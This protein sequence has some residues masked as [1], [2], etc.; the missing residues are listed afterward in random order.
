LSVSQ[1][2]QKGKIMTP[3][4]TTTIE[5]RAGAIAKRRFRV[6]ASG[7]TA[8]VAGS[9]KGV[10]YDVTLNSCTCGDF[11]NVK[12]KRNAWNA[13]NNPTVPFE[14]CKHVARMRQ[15]AV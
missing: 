8:R 15:E 11:V 3:K 9:K 10:F 13:E 1:K 14:M 4:L 7:E 12:A 5:E 6:H 2:K